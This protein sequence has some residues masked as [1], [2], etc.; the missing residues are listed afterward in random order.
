MPQRFFLILLFLLTGCSSAYYSAMESVG[1]PKREILVHRI[2][3]AREEQS[4]AKEQ[5][6]SALQRFTELTHFDGGELQQKYDELS[7][8]YEASVDK[9]DAVHRRIADIE[10][11]AQA[12]FE[13]WEEE[14]T[15]YSNPSLRRSSARQ[16]QETRRRYQRLINAMKRAEGKIQPVLTVFH[17]QV[18]FLKHNLNARAIASLQTELTSIEAGVSALIQEMERSIQEADSFISAMQTNS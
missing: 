18:L 9:A 13:E 5:F 2:E 1:F 12:L 7:A 3:K 8:A 17:D 4:E 10:D 6:K 11:V 15:Q 14:L 16:L